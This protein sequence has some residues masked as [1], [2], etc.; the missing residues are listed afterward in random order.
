MY[1]KKQITWRP[2]TKKQLN[3]LRTNINGY[4]AGPDT[5]YLTDEEIE[6]IVNF[7]D[8]IASIKNG[9]IYQAKKFK[10]TPAQQREVNKNITL[11]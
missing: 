8:H 9:S 11:F 4:V 10:R 5:D 2:L 6:A 3:N 7:K 1:H